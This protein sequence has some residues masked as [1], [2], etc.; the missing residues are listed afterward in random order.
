MGLMKTG[1]AFPGAMDHCGVRA[2]LAK[3]EEFTSEM[4]PTLK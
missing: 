1:L 2:E 3:F 4:H